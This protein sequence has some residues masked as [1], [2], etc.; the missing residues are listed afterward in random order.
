M[1]ELAGFAS[2]HRTLSV[3]LER[4]YSQLARPHDA[5][6]FAASVRQLNDEICELQRDVMWSDMDR[7]KLP[8]LGRLTS[9]PL[10][11]A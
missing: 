11:S 8:R 5:V 2:R 6:D 1:R 3:P 7:S 4:L 9:S 10:P